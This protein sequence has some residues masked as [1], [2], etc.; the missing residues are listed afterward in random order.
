M[1]T[2]QRVE[3]PEK[4]S[5]VHCTSSTVPT[6]LIFNTNNQS[7]SEENL[8]YLPP[9][10]ENKLRPALLQDSSTC[11]STTCVSL[12]HKTKIAGSMFSETSQSHTPSENFSEDPES[13]QEIM[14][15][16]PYLQLQS[17]DSML[18]LEPLTAIFAD[19]FPDSDISFDKDSP[20]VA[21]FL[22][23][24]PSVG[25]FMFDFEGGRRVKR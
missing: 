11:Y 25:T 9:M 14:L 21:D 7:N 2:R 24:L 5:T 15:S 20:Y 18:T 8:K 10:T 23:P 6:F 1:H 22:H 13:D 16:G 3:I 12:K 17:V 19:D 4:K